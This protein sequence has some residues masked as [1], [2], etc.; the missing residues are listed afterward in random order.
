MVLCSH[1]KNALDFLDQLSSVYQQKYILTPAVEVDGTQA[2]IDEVCKLAESNGLP[3]EDYR[4]SLSEFSA[5]EVRRHLSEVLLVV[6][7]FSELSVSL[8]VTFVFVQ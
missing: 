2:F 3:S 4:S 1:K 8:S 7:P 6:L 5:D